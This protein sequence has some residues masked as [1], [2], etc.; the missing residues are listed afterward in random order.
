MSAIIRGMIPAANLTLLYGQLPL[1]ARF[2]SAA[3]DGFGAVEI[4]FP[5]DQSPAWYA[6]RLREHGL[7]LVLVNTPVDP[8]LAPMGRAAQAGAAAAF[9]ADFGRAAAL[10]DATGCRAIHVMAGCVPSGDA[11]S[12]S[13]LLENL[14]G[15]C[16]AYPE[17]TVQLEALNCHDVPGYFY[18]EPATVRGILQEAGLG[19]LGMQ[20]DF[21]HVLRQGLSLSAELEASLPW[22]R[23]VQVAGSPDRH[24]PDLSRDGLRAGFERLHQAGYRGH[25]G[26]EYRP[27]SSITEGLKWAD[28]LLGTVFHSTGGPRP[29]NLDHS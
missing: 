19:S 14:A 6:D 20:F 9:R 3:R 10:C 22:I 16:A 4:L 21:Y 1:E 12:R 5:Y 13:A 28:E 7:Q 25:V 29:L 24:E 23:H 17:L 8:S 18:S 11:A 15:V 27:A 2:A 26:Y